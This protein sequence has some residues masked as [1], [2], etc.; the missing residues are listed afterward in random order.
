M[1]QHQHPEAIPK[2][3]F[4]LG[5]RAKPGKALGSHI[6]NVQD[7]YVSRIFALLLPSFF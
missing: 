4:S 1:F 7:V 3:N 5:L 2:S 6:T